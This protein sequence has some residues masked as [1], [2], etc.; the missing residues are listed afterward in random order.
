MH[1]CDHCLLEFSEKMAVIDEIRGERKIFCCHGCRGIYRFI[2][3]E[4]L[5]DFY[6]KRTLSWIPG[7]PETADIDPRAFSDS[8]RKAGDSL[9][10]DM[11]LE[12]I[13][14]ASCVWLVEKVLLRTEG[15]TYARVNYA[16]H[17]AK[18]GWNPEKTNLKA[19]INRIRSTGYTPKPFAAQ[20]HEE[21]FRAVKKD[22]LIRFGTA[23]FFT[24]QL[25][26][27]SIA[28]YAGYFQGI[29]DRTRGA[30]QVISLV[31]ATPVVF[32]AG[33]P[34]FQ[35]ALRGMKART[36]NMDVL[37]TTGASAAYC[38]SIYQITGGGEVYFDTA[39]M[40]ITFILLGRLIET[41]AKGRASEVISRLLSLSPKE[42]KRL[43]QSKEHRTKT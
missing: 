27:F 36:L 30:F 33:W 10:A 12:G 20:V 29:G 6:S 3:E 19:I 18:I 5:T 22:L 7:P 32:Y 37:I 21:H 39:A 14:C 23:A 2:N 4:G 31:L 9:E 25:M 42:A 28:L 1:K 16:T 41:G 34:F 26:L 38:Y 43:I 35:G 40:I 13:R 24:M 17:R 11:I 8:L 15:I